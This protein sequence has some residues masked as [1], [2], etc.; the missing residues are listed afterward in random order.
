MSDRP[1]TPDSPDDPKRR[2]G[3][4]RPAAPGSWRTPESPETPAGGGW[5]VPDAAQPRDA[6]FVEPTPSPAETLTAEPDASGAWHLPPDAAQDEAESAAATPT[7]TEPAPAEPPA[8]EPVT[9]LPFDELGG[10][11]MTSDVLEGQADSQDDQ[12]AEAPQTGIEY[13]GED[14]DDDDDGFSMS[15]LVALA[16]LVDSPT[17]E[18]QPETPVPS[19]AT[20]AE[21][22][23]LAWERVRA[24]REAEAAAD[25]GT[26]GVE[27]LDPAEPVA[28]ADQAAE[29]TAA[30][31]DQAAEDQA[32]DGPLDAA[33]IARRELER[34]QQFGDDEA[35]DEGDAARA[36]GPASADQ[37]AAA[38]IS[39]QPLDPERFTREQLERLEESRAAAAAESQRLS[40]EEEDLAQQYR[41]AQDRVRVLQQ[42]YQAGTISRDELQASLRSAMV[43][44]TDNIWWM[45]GVESGTWYKY[46]NNTWAQ[47]Q[48]D[49]LAKLD[50]AGAAA[51]SAEQ[52]PSMRGPAPRTETGAFDASDLPSLPRLDDQPAPVSQSQPGTGVSD[53]GE[54]SL[55][56]TSPIT[57]DDLE[58]LPQ[59][60]T[61][62]R[63]PEATLV[64][65]RG[66]DLPGEDT[67]LGRA[68]DTEPLDVDAT[69]AGQTV[70]AGAYGNE[71]IAAPGVQVP[72]Q[73]AAQPER[74]P[75]TDQA[76]R[77]ARERT[78]RNLLIA[79]AIVVGVVALVGA[80][81]LLLT[82]QAYNSIVDPYRPAIAALAN[83]QPDFQT[84]RIVDANGDVMAELIQGSG[85]ARDLIG[86]N[87][88]APILV[89]AVISS[90]N[91]R[92]FIDPG[93]D[94]IA[95]FR[96]FLENLSAGGVQ[97]GGSTITQQIARDLILNNIDP[98]PERKL[99]EILVAAELAQQ[100]DK[101]FILE[102]YLNEIFLGN[103]SFGVEAA[104]QFYFDAS[105]A[106]L[107]L[108]Q[109]ALIAGLIPAPS[110][111]NPVV[112]EDAAFTQME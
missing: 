107:N 90:E 40:A 72:Q 100:Y 36:D 60:G 21:Y 25:Q 41:D 64:G 24:E 4:Y 19:A 37:A 93:F 38:S 18:P 59:Q 66:T 26:S 110:I 10:F 70:R 71:T 109:A 58:R 84:A 73:P 33:A 68:S 11:G 2:S 94:P 12:A 104:S 3:W 112:S 29:P 65:V 98:T 34:L 111:T 1:N 16:S 52:P 48:P 45:M 50:S 31:A 51:A 86:L 95:I 63:D 6:S 46:E 28:Q 91:E 42:Q 82:V 15:E 57:E 67:L 81:A 102:L 101:E 108:P 75:R 23:R 76:I 97:S 78:T 44:D 88:V 9:V 8:A 53:F 92:F 20:P 17:L 32:D 106:D 54:G 89:H 7:D 74:G 69:V 61:P 49:V 55:A 30:P 5:R 87:E 39:D 99:E 79:A 35:D 96:A 103:Q 85:G 47:A 27:T 77:E 43:L 62:Y 14:D 56:P 22:A 80:A 83:Y 105:A 13:F